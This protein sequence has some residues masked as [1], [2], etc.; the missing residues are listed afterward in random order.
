[1]K[2]LTFEVATSLSWW[3]AHNA[4]V[5]G[6]L[7]APGVAVYND[8]KDRSYRLTHLQSG[9]AFGP[10]MS[11]AQARQVVKRT[12]HL[13]NWEASYLVLMWQPEM[14]A[15]GCIMREITGTVAPATMADL[16]Y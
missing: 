3:G 9:L 10:S 2:R 11:W 12:R 4:T 14:I 13:L 7:L 5:S 8:K 16:D 15:A 1:M 6:Y